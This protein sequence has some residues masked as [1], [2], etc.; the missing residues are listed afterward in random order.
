MTTE[1]ALSSLRFYCGLAE[2]CLTGD[3]AT[4]HLTQLR[5]DPRKENLEALIRYRLACEALERA[6][7]A[8]DWALASEQATTG[9]AK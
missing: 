8:L 2:G 9:G 3:G 1:H 4:E 6:Y 5:D 7:A